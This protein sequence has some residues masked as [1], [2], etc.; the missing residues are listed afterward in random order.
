[1]Y[2][3]DKETQ[4]DNRHEKVFMSSM[5]SSNQK[6]QIDERVGRGEGQEN[7]IFNLMDRQKSK[8]SIGLMLG[9]WWG[10]GCPHALLMAA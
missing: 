8:R 10:D 2:N 5:I 6:N 3:F 1:M 7:S 9:G 4:M